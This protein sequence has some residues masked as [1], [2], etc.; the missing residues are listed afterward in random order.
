MC[1]VVALQLR[2]HRF[3]LAAM[4]EVEE[5]GFHD[6]EFVVAEGDF[7]HAELLGIGVEMATAQARTE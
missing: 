5:E 6:V 7:R 2:R 4:K 1:A 3:Q